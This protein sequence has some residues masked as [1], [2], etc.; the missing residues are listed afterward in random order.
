I[1]EGAY[2]GNRAEVLT[3]QAMMQDFGRTVADTGAQLAFQDF[4]ALRGGMPGLYGMVP[5]LA[6]AGYDL[7]LSPAETLM[8]A[9]QTRRGFAQDDI[10]EALARFEMQQNVPWIGLDRYISAIQG[11]PSFQSSLATTKTP[12]PSPIVSGLK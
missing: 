6:G 4:Q 3:P 10:Q 9:G 7:S 5:Q 8:G 1:M 11:A 2:G 12:T